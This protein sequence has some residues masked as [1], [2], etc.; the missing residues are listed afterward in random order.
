MRK[1][2]KSICSSTAATALLALFVVAPIHAQSRYVSPPGYI[3]GVVQSEK[4]PKR[5]FG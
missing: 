1:I 4:G 2:M 5:A 3:T